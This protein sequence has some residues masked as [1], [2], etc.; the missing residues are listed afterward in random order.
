MMNSLLKWDFT[1]WELNEIQVFHVNSTT[2]LQLK[3]E[4]SNSL[5]N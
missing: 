3:T 5:G 2:M 4:F 1:T